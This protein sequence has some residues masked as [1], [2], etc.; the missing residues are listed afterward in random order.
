MRLEKEA[1]IEKSRQLFYGNHSRKDDIENI[2]WCMRP[3][4][5]GADEVGDVETSSDKDIDPDS[6][7]PNADSEPDL[8]LPDLDFS[9]NGSRDEDEEIDED[10]EEIG[11]EDDIRMDDEDCDEELEPQS[12]RK[13]T[14]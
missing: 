4:E 7:D 8:N 9:M 3:T 12:K 11:D 14:K 2:T 10:D 1:Q 5:A 6:G 13:K